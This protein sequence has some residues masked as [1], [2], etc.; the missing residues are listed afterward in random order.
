MASELEG[1][2]REA[3]HRIWEHIENDDLDALDEVLAE[4][5][6]LRVPGRN[7]IHGIE[8]YRDYIRTYKT[9][10]PDTTFEVHDMFVDGDAVI[11]HFSWTATHEGEIEGIDATGN[12]VETHG[13]TI[14][15]FEDGKAVE[16]IN[17][18]DNLDF[19]QQLG[20]MESPTD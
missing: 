2:N 1:T 14:N 3:T 20:V 19:F 10:F 8:G 12:T 9:A 7:E 11:T 18:W 16:D 15:R 6:V 13:M 5:V 4:D 17:Y